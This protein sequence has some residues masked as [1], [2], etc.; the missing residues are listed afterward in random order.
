MTHGQR[1][2]LQSRVYSAHQP[3]SAE[4][5]RTGRQAQVRPGQ[6]QQPTHFN[7]QRALAVLSD[8]K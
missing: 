7:I 3:E 6:S 5:R 2:S 8:P 4:V 1:M